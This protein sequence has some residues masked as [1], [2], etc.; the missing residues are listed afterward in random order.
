MRSGR[1]EVEKFTWIRLILE[2][3]FGDDPLKFLR[4]DIFLKRVSWISSRK[5]Q[6]KDAAAGS[7]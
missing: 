5:I 6:N 3:K 4:N 2:V 1:I 7:V